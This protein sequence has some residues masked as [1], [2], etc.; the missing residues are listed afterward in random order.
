MHAFRGRGRSEP[1]I[2]YWFHTPPNVR[3]GRA[4]LDEAAIRSIEECN[5]ELHFD[6][7]RILKARA[8]EPSTP[9]DRGRERRQRERGGRQAR[10]RG[11]A[12]LPTP[13]PSP[14]PATIAGPAA[15]PDSVLAPAPEIAAVTTDQ[16][17]APAGASAAEP[18]PSRQVERDVER[19]ALPPGLHVEERLGPEGFSRL[20]GRYAELMAR[21]T[22]RVTDPARLEELRAQAERLNPDTW[23]TD[24]EARAGIE[25]F[26]AACEAIRTKLGRRRRRSR[27]GGARRNR[28]RRA[29]A[30]TAA[31]TAAEPVPAGG[32][33]EGPAVGDAEDGPGASEP[34]PE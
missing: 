30:A 7:T 22:E 19:P 25:G 18:E 32:G 23:I 8:E 16:E 31:A 21:I 5:P 14:E 20:R 17:V 2:L 28:A 6:W 12:G 29:Q 26:D 15:P 34:K 11:R 10:A 24:E 1:R 13:R 3:V 4:A 33:A 27:R 9:P